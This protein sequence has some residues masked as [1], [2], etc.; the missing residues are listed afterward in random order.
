MEY[1]ICKAPTPDELEN[2]VMAKLK[3]GWILQGGVSI[4]MVETDD[5]SER[6]YCQAMIK[7]TAH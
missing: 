6:E 4:G 3:D 1:F 7:S 5:Y 2:I